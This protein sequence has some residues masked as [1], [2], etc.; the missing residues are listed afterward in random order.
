MKG[1]L[2]W[3]ELPEK[4]TIVQKIDKPGLEESRLVTTRALGCSW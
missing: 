2:D 3:L 1:A 4:S